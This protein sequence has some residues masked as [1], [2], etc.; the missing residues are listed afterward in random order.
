MGQAGGVELGR[1]HLGQQGQLLLARQQQERRQ[2]LGIAET[3]IGQGIQLRHV[4][5]D[6]AG[7]GAGTAA[8]G[9]AQI[10]LDES[11]IG[12]GAQTAVGIPA[13][14]RG[15]Y[16]GRAGARQAHVGEAAGGHQAVAVA[17]VDRAAGQHV[18][19]AGPGD[20]DP[21][22]VRS[23][24]VGGGIPRGVVRDPA[25]GF[26]QAHVRRTEVLA[27]VVEVADVLAGD[28]VGHLGQGDAAASTGDAAADGD[29]AH[30]LAV[31]LMQGRQRQRH[32]PEAEGSHIE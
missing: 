12:G 6:C 29:D 27:E 13:Q 9:G 7:V 11:V 30:R 19:I 4:L 8:A 10:M 22:Q 21:R 32:Q 26:E 17:E 15:H 2:R 24:L 25:A 5:R 20:M 23:Q 1:K 18:D 28:E 14:P 16:Q 3:G 31:A